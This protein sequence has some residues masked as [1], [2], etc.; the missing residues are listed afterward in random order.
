MKRAGFRSVMC[1]PESA[2]E[3]TLRT[4][5]KGFSKRAVERAAKA[6]AEAELPTY[7]FFMLGAPG[8]T[9][10]TVRETLAFCRRACP[11][12]I[13]WCCSR[14]ASAST[15]ARRSSAPAKSSA[16]SSRTTRCSS[17]PGTCRPSSISAS[18]TTLVSAAADHPNWMTN[19]ETM[20]S[21]GMAAV[22]KGA[23][24]MLG[25]KGP[26]W[27]H[28]PKLFRW[29][30]ASARASAGSMHAA[31]MRGIVDVQHHR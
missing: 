2:S 24:R 23:F 18:S 14:R 13:T 28:L 9:L 6:L 15:R 27:Q 17:R 20:M 4:L 30:T 21:P 26:F 5:Q 16:G 10:D 1:T 8:E 12:R 25:W 19:A 29:S 22:M 11:A 7:W 3:V 31:N